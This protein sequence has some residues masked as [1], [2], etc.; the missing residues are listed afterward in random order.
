MQHKSEL[1]QT[2]I[3]QE[4]L[5]LREKLEHLELLVKQLLA[6]RTM[7]DANAPGLNN[8]EILTAEKISNVVHDVLEEAGVDVE[9]LQLS[10]PYYG[11]QWD[12]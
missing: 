8:N 2:E 4:K 1:D 10:I 5:E 9:P 3:D 11:P 7:T 6:D 12:I